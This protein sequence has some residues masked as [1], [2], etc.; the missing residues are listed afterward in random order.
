MT[1]HKTLH[2]IDTLYLTNFHHTL[3]FVLVDAYVEL[4]QYL[5]HAQALAQAIEVSSDCRKK[6]TEI[7]QRLS[8]PLSMLEEMADGMYDVYRSG[9]EIADPVQWDGLETIPLTETRRIIS[10]LDAVEQETIK[11]LN[12]IG[13]ALTSKPIVAASWRQ[14]ARLRSFYKLKPVPERPCYKPDSAIRF[15]GSPP[16]DDAYCFAKPPTDFELDPESHYLLNSEFMLLT[17]LPLFDD[18]E[19]EVE[20][21]LE[22]VG[23]RGPSEEARHADK[24]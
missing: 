4:R 15:C 21:K 6:Y 10:Q 16:W 17:W 1:N 9:D 18:I 24:L 22:V 20:I 11:T 5:K 12:S 7:V 23:S 19:V 8:L 3:L 13:E 14:W 2:A